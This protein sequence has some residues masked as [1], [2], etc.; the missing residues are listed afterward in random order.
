MDRWLFFTKQSLIDNRISS[1]FN[2]NGGYWIPQLKITNRLQSTKSQKKAPFRAE[3]SNG[4]LWPA[5]LNPS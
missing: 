2:V 3:L 5:N 4:A 1:P